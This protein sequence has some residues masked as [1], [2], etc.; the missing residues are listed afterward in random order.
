[1]ALTFTTINL[2]NYMKLNKEMA[3]RRKISYLERKETLIFYRLSCG[4]KVAK[5]FQI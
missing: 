4:D 2:R 5:L 3:G 1:M